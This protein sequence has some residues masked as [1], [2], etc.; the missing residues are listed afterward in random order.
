MS[1][2][3]HRELVEIPRQVNSCRYQ[4]KQYLTSKQARN[5]ER[6]WIFGGW[7]RRS[8]GNV[9]DRVREC[10]HGL[11]V[12]PLEGFSGQYVVVGACGDSDML[13]AFSTDLAGAGDYD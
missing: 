4:G 11:H 6:L 5:Y 3:D 2:S 12:A 8:D 10:L 7:I 13:R 9:G 1:I